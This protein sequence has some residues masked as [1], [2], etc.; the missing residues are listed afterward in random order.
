MSSVVHHSQN[1][2]EQ[3][4]LFMCI[5]LSARNCFIKLAC[6]SGI[7]VCLALIPNANWFV[8]DMQRCADNVAS[9]ASK[10][11]LGKLDIPPDIKPEGPLYYSHLQVSTYAQ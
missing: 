7:R 11:D 1:T 5:P 4:L 10:L 8:L 6:C 9:I 2:G 3:H